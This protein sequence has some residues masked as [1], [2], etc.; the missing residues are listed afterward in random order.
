MEICISLLLPSSFKISLTLFS[1][2]LN[3]ISICSIIYLYVYD[4]FRIYIKGGSK[5]SEECTHN[6]STCSANCSSKEKA[7]LTEQPHALSSVKHIIAVV[8]GKGGVGKS[9]VTSMLAVSAAREGKKV[10]ILDADITGSA[11]GP[12]RG[13]SPLRL[14]RDRYLDHVLPAFTCRRL[15]E[16]HLNLTVFVKA[17]YHCT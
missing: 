3:F 15:S 6:C 11:T 10:A 14:G 13:G 9:S 4:Y 16:R 7:S 12:P 8:S 5:M 17:F 1:K 2:L